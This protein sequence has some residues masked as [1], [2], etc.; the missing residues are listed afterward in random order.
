[1]GWSFWHPWALLGLAL[2][3]VPLWLHRQRKKPSKIIDMATMQWLPQTKVSP[4]HWLIQHWLLML[5]RMA[6]LVL[7]VLWLAQPLLSAQ[8]KRMTWRFVHPAAASAN[9]GEGHW[10]AVGFPPLSD[11]QPN[12]ADVPI[13]SLLRELVQRTPADQTVRLVL[14][15]HATGVDAA[16]VHLPNRFDIRW[17]N[18]AV[19]ASP[20]HDAVSGTQ[21]QQSSI[22]QPLAEALW[23][24]DEEAPTQTMQPPKTH[25]DGLTGERQDATEYWLWWLLAGMLLERVLAW[26]PGQKRMA[27]A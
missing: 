27:A 10:L 7:L 19:D 12:A 18:V 15:T 17:V 26:W 2:L 5:V 11:A 20:N 16:L 8:A 4:K 23:F 24:S 21:V 25:Q 13:S 3:L 9:L 14:P 1:M 6:L 22:P